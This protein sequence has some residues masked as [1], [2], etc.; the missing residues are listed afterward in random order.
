MKFFSHQ[1]GPSQID[2]FAPSQIAILVLAVT[3]GGVHCGLLGWGALVHS[4]TLNEP[5]HLAAGISNWQF[6]Q[7][8]IYRVNPPLV[9]MCAAAPVLVAGCETDWNAFDRGP[10]A[11]PEFQ[12]GEDF[13]A[14][15]GKRS[16]WLFTLARWACIPF[17]VLGGVICFLWARKLYGWGAEVFALTLWCF[18]PNILAHGQLIT[19]D[20]CATSLGLA[21]C[22]TFWHWLKEPTWTRTLTSGLALGIAELAKMTLV[23]FFVM[24]PLI[25]LIY[26]WSDRISLTRRDWLREL[27][28]LSV[29]F[30]VAL[31]ILNVG[32]AFEGTGTRL[33]EFKFVSATLGAEEG[34]QK[35][36]AEGGNRFADTWLAGVPVPLP[37]NYV[38][39]ID[40]QKRDFESYGQ[41][42]YLRG[43]FSPRGWWYY[44]L[45]A[46]AIK[47]PLG[48]W[49]LVALAAVAPRIA[50]L[51]KPAV[52]P[53]CEAT[54]KPA[55]AWRDEFVL[56]CPAVVILA[57]VSSRTGFSQHMR[58]VL[59]AFPFVFIWIGRLAPVLGRQHSVVTG[60]ATAALVWSIGSSLW[61]YPHSL[62]YFNELAGGPIG[63]PAHLI[64]S[65]V[66]WGQ[67]LL[68]LKRWLDDHPEAAPLKLAYFGY[69]DPIHAGIEYAAP[70]VLPPAGATPAPKIPPG[71]YAISVNFV[72][73]FPY[74]I[75][76]GDGTKGFLPQGALTA[77]QSLEPIA[78]AGYS[79]YIYHVTGEE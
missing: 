12:L 58:Y 45:Y 43:K 34:K 29:R 23:V 55:V 60:L 27:A 64:H 8:E 47:V 42:S 26:R 77:F 51:G 17:S 44:Y 56:L 76:H 75:Y 36:P 37:T 57:F 66:D 22:Y 4:S 39:G 63:G 31:Y 61:Y 18:C 70:E 74:Q 35:A 25:W 15:N 69:F 21:A 24:W 67:D 33:D 6:G 72:R 30:L 1:F 49:I 19:P 68:F 52:A 59:P 2:R 79:I 38:L 32:Y 62:S 10:R 53:R 48:T 65:N 54:T 7:F 20:V 13:V 16:L 73:G 50:L 46:L 11:R 41:P 5:G 3:L 28:M 78:M 14:A 40:L 9:R 71:W